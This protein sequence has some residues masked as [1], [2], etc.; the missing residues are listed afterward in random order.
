MTSDPGPQ[1]EPTI[2]PGE[3]LPGGP[4]ALDDEEKYGATPPE[5]VVPDLDPDKNP[6]TE[7]KQTP[8]E[9]TEPDDKQ[10]EPGG[11]DAD[12]TAGEDVTGD[13]NPEP[14]A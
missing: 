10:Q 5:P 9:V 1:P 6:S 14:P 11:S 4:D 8:D 12:A 13:E 2:E 3:P 7:A